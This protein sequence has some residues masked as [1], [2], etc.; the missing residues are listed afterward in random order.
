MHPLLRVVAVVVVVLSTFPFAAL[1]ARAEGLSPLERRLA[2]TVDRH[3]PA[4]LALLEQ[5][6]NVNSGTHHHEGVQR[7][8]AMF[9]TEFERLGFRTRWV[10]GAAFGR[11]GHLI[12]EHG[13]RGPKVLLIGHLDTVFEPTSPFQRFTRLDDSTATGPGICDMKGGDVIMLLALRALRENGL[14]DRLRITAI[15]TGDEES[16]GEPRSLARAELWRAAE[17][18]DV[19]IGFEDGD[20]D[21]RRAI[22]ARRGAS[23]WRLRVHGTPAHSSL[24]FSADVGIGSIL[25]TARILQGFRDSLGVEPYLTFNPG[26]IVGG[27]TLTLEPEASRGTAFGKTNVVAESTFVSG[28]LRTL[29]LEQRSRAQTTMQR[30]VAEASP[31]CS[32]TLVFEDGYPPLPPTD[33]NRR[34]LAMVDRASRDLGLGPVDAVDPSRAGAADVSWLH[35]RVP[36]ILDA[37][38]LKGSGGHTVQETA[39]LRTLPVQAKRTAVVLA[40]LARAADARGRTAR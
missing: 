12:A 22:I 15:L 25:E 29:T 2:A 7:T 37:M 14:L 34:L 8:G 27:T 6:V 9:A 21:P 17:G 4:S 26:L 13:S 28:D 10:D 3:A 20:G 11:A 40:R 18:A 30:I 32:A 16:M 31:G 1:R 24:V 39:R 19:A 5:V 38:G 33:G 35:G 36:M 23:L